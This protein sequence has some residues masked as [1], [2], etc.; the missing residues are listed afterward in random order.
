MPEKTKSIKNSEGEIKKYVNERYLR[1][2]DILANKKEEIEEMYKNK[3]KEFFLLSNKIFKKNPWP[4]GGYISYLSIF[5]FGP[6]F[7][8]EKSFQI[9]AFDKKKMI[10]FSIFH[11]I[12]HF[13]FYDY[14][15]KNYSKIFQRLDKE[16]GFFWDM[17]E[18]F[19]AVIQDSPEFQKIQGKIKN[20]GYPDHKEKIK[21][22]SSF[23]NGDVDLWI[24]K[25]LENF[26][27]SLS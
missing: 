3:E 6:R 8:E 7:L 10:L 20:I 19:N 13:Q 14:C 5:D 11:E 12:L 15:L 2:K 24:E 23:W 22:A 26:S 16:K 18:V 9:F 1:N 25:Y 21:I 27:I 4:K 17:S